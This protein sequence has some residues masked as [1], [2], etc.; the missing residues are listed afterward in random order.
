MPIVPEKVKDK[1]HP[2][3]TAISA[4]SQALSLAG[5]AVARESVFD[6]LISCC[7]GD[8]YS[9]KLPLPLITLIQSGKAALGKN[10]CVKEYMIVPRPDMPMY[11]A[12]SAATKMHEFM[13]KSMYAKGGVGVKNLSDVGAL[14]P[15]LDKPEQGLDMIAEA[16]TQL[17]LQ[18]GTDFFFVLN[19]SAHECFDY[20][21]G[22]YDV[23]TGMLKSADDMPD[24]WTDICNRYP[25]II[26][27]IDPMR[28]EE[29]SQ[30]NSI[31][32]AISGCCLVIADKA[33]NRPGLLKDESL[34]FYDFATSGIVLKLDGA[35]TITH[36]VK[37]SKKMSDMNNTVVLS[38]GQHATNDTT[39]IDV[40]IACQARFIKLGAPARGERVV[41]YNRLIELEAE[42]GERRA[43]WPTLQFPSIPP[44]APT[45]APDEAEQAVD[46]A[47]D[48]MAD[49][50]Q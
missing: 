28:C 35:N 38:D 30:W 25:T 36:I 26:G 24:F 22:K 32:S 49:G 11:E 31:C 12:V 4:V 20:D 44:K 7:G 19:S 34:D 42:L 23:I 17:G 46:P 3:S 33:Y 18:M 9:I 14:C 10:N 1:N 40:A 21:K 13:L 39:I 41:K 50:K 37:C 45:P 2:G 29:K 43:E 5:A 6:H 16:A 48:E 8:N 47:A 15:T 27:L